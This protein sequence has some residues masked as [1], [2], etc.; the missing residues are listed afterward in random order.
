MKIYMHYKQ[1]P[2]NVIHTNIMYS[3]TNIIV[4]KKYMRQVP[5]RINPKLL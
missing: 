4:D 1:T 5:F 3:R 2:W